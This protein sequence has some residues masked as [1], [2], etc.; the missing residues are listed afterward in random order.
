M[1]RRPLC[2]AAL[3]VSVLT[4]LCIGAPVASAAAT[5]R[6]SVPVPVPVARAEQLVT[7]SL[8]ASGALAPS[9]T[10]PMFRSPLARHVVL[11]FIGA[12]G[13]SGVTPTELADTSELVTNMTNLTATGALSEATPGW[14]DLN[15]PD[16]PGFV[17]TVHS[18][19]DRALLGIASGSPAALRRMLRTPANAAGRLAK[20]VAPIL[21]ATHLDGLDLDVEGGSTAER[22]A[23]TTF[24]TVLHRALVHTS[25]G[26][27]LVVNVAPT[28]ASSSG[29]FNVRALGANASALFVMDYDLAPGGA[30]GPNA[31]L[32][33]ASP[34]LSVSSSLVA[35]TH[36]VPAQKLILGMPFYGYDFPT[37]TS[38]P[39]SATIGAGESVT[40]GNIVA[41]GHVGR[42][43]ATSLTPY[44]VFKRGKQWHETYYDDPVSIALRTAL[45]AVLGLGGVGAWSLGQEG[46]EVAML[47][48]LDG[49]A[50][51]L[52]LPVASG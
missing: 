22:S 50:A 3:V 12:A 41:V 5:S 44:Y 27:S 14:A 25:P 33:A 42:W 26:L 32:V 7:A 29:F 35:F 2:F 36:F 11:G 43:D 49:G 51:P 15:D 21:T 1:A 23:F 20:A 19:G 52:R 4:A 38:A 46:D 16:F 47:Q 34:R 28:A 45:A 40:Y 6:R 10:G 30:A 48:A 9:P 13:F 37:K 39:G 8:P 17:T 18:A 31:P 24:V